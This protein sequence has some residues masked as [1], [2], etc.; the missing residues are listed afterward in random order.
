[1]LDEMESE[2]WQLGFWN[3]Q[4]KRFVPLA[5]LGWE[6]AKQYYAVP[7]WGEALALLAWRLG[8]MGKT[9]RG[10]RITQYAGLLIQ[11]RDLLRHIRQSRKGGIGAPDNVYL[12]QLSREWIDK[13]SEMLEEALGGGKE[14]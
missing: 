3:E 13:L 2:D 1:M 9:D 8:E 7:G 5:G 4:E 10:R 6:E 14:E 11:L 12:P